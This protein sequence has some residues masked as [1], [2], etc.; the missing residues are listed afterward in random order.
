M[1][2]VRYDVLI[3]GFYSSY[4]I[5][6]LRLN[7][8]R[9]VDDPYG[10]RIISLDP[11]YQSNAYIDAAGLADP[12][13]WPELAMPS[14]PN[15]SDDE[16]APAMRRRH[17]GFPGANLKYTTTILGP[18]R[19]GAMGLRVNGKRQS[20]P[21]NSVRSSLRRGANDPA[22]L[23]TTAEDSTPIIT[24]V[25]AATPTSPTKPEGP[26][27]P[28]K[29]S[30]AAQQP[31]ATPP[32]QEGPPVPRKEFVPK[33][34]FKGAA[35]ME[36]RRRQRMAARARGPGVA[37]RAPMVPMTVNPE[38]S[39]SSSS[40]PE[41]DSEE[42]GGDE[43]EDDFGDVDDSMETNVDDFDPCVYFSPLYKSH[44]LY[45]HGIPATSLPVEQRTARPRARRCCLE[46]LPGR[47]SWLHPSPQVRVH[48]YHV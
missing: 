8:L 30:M 5:H 37:P 2:R 18:S 46:Y 12:N 20:M 19:T 6:S 28:I 43:D 29:E 1:S 45:Q 41:V 47:L 26:R 39:S 16:S 38:I 36:A 7:Y 32:T 48:A 14:S 21:R 33:F 44:T 25:I 34:N 27:S 31:V 17:S 23:S 4:L 42:E 9:N 3:L 24:E 11:S 35:E 13:R 22:S 15:V 40:E 10:A